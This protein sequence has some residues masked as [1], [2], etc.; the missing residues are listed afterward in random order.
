VLVGS[1]S[2][3]FI[4]GGGMFMIVVAL[5]EMAVDFG[6]PREVPSLAFSLQFIGSGF[7]GLIMGRIVDR[8]GFGAPAFLASIMVGSGGML[9]SAIDS[10]WQL[11]AIYLVMFGLSGQGALAA[12][13]L[14]NIARWYTRHRGRAVGIV[15]SG[16]ALA[17]IVW[18]PV[19]G[20]VMPEIG[21]RSMFFWYGLFSLCIMLPLC[22]IVYH[23]PPVQQSDGLER[24]TSGSIKS[25]KVPKISD[26]TLQKGL[27]FAIFGCCVAMSLPL[28]HLV[29]FVTDRGHPIQN[30]VGVQSTMLLC[31]FISRALLL[32]LLSDR[33]GGIRAL[34]IFASVQ[35]VM[36]VVFTI[37]YQLWVLY[38]VA[39]LFGLGYGGLFPVYAVAIRDHLP[40][41]EVGKRTGVVFFVG[42][43][44]MG[45]GGWI[46]GYL[47]DQTGSYTLPFLIGAVFNAGTVILVL[48][49]MHR[50]RGFLP[51]RLAET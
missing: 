15:A 12:P 6:W 16:Q 29:S 1:V 7:G 30:A 19:F 11:Y 36:L 39:A 4:T 45:F 17:G 48:Y 8:L 34:L 23:K 43:V 18:L 50:L 31:A 35:A 38:V 9:V 27:C 41:T 37:T 33:W 51:G 26:S 20:Y 42:A 40:I 49:L 2:M 21:W 24:T 32:G 28:G 25:L 10:A 3:L 22:F 46:G 14:A 13:A 47:F 44:A 5:K